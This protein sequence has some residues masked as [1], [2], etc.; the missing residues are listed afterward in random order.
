MFCNHYYDLNSC[1]LVK[2]SLRN[3]FFYVDVCEGI[4]AI[5]M[6]LEHT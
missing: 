6:I 3:K 5:G 4:G 1:L 2:I